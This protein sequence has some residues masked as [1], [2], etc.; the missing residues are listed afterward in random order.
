MIAALLKAIRKSPSCKTPPKRPLGGP[1]RQGSRRAF[2]V[3]S[4]PV[5]KARRLVLFLPTTMDCRPG[6]G[7]CCIVPGIT[8]AL[9]GLPGGK[10]AMVRCLHLSSENLCQIFTHPDRPAVCAS[11]SASIEMCG[12]TAAE[13]TSYLVRLELATRPGNFH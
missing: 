3:L 4:P 5:L 12:S 1:S 7:A 2:G 10:P 9:P 13:A 8:S 11:L 6:C